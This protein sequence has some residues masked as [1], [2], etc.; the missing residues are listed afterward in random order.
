MKAMQATVD[1]KAAHEALPLPS[2]TG[3]LLL[4]LLLL[5]HNLTANKQGKKTF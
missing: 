4:L 1:W 3:L 2:G 5:V